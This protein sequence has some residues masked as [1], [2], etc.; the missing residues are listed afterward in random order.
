MPI[1]IDERE[2][3]KTGVEKTENVVEKENEGVVVEDAA[4]DKFLKVV[5]KVGETAKIIHAEFPA[6]AK[7]ERRYLMTKSGQVVETTSVNCGD[8]EVI[9]GTKDG[10]IFVYKNAKKQAMPY[11]Y[12]DLG[13]KSV[14]FAKNVRRVKLDTLS[15]VISATK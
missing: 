12:I 8:G 14:V 3:T 9:F 5:G 4:L 11:F 10:K 2:E 13:D 6:V 15:A 1:R 7:L